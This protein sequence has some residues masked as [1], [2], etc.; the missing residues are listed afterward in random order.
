MSI[1]SDN[2]SYTFSWPWRWGAHLL[3]VLFHPVFVPVYFMYFLLFQ[4]PN[5]YLGFDLA[6]KVVILLQSVAMFTFFPL[7]TV[8]L[9]KALGFIKSIQLHD[10]K[11][12]IIPLVASGIWYFWIWYVWRNLPEQP[13]AAIQLALGVWI[14]SVAALMLN[15]RMKISLHALSLGATLALLLSLSI[16][17]N[18]HYGVWLSIAFIITG[19]VSSSRLLVSD[20]RPSEVYWGLLTGAISMLVAGVFA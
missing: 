13:V 2:Q 10:Q 15:T 9:L 16:K 14:T 8:G 18:L 5:Q 3:S 7:V 6:Q 17:E 4:H 12:R 11:D 20:H 1:S 19:A